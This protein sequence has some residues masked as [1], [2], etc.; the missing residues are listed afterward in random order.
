[1]KTRLTILFMLLAFVGFG[2]SAARKLL[3]STDKPPLLTLSDVGSFS[4]STCSGWT[5]PQFG[6]GYTASAINYKFFEPDLTI[7]Q[8]KITEVTLGGM[9]ITYNGSQ[10]IVND[11]IDFS[12]GNIEFNITEY[13]SVAITSS[14]K[15]KILT[16]EY[17][18]YSNEVEKRFTFNGCPD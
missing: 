13:T 3:L 8:I 4:T 18:Q 1:M 7:T 5:Y 6:L 12:L 2:Q 17:S 11:I 9:S 15:F 14:F 16:T 10:I